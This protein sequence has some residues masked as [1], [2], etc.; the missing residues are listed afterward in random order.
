MM[1]S[2]RLWISKP[3]ARP[4]PCTGPRKEKRLSRPFLSVN[5]E[6]DERQ[7]DRQRQISGSL[8]RNSV[9]GP[10]LADV[11]R[12]SGEHCPRQPRAPEIPREYRPMTG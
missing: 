12:D 5:A 2:Y 6:A 3:N 11:H 1:K 8:K 4:L 9:S 10:T 7:P